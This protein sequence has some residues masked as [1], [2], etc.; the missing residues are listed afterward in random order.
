MDESRRLQRSWCS[1]GKSAFASDRWPHSDSV[2]RDALRIL[3][4]VRALHEAGY[5]RIRVHAGLSPSGTHWRCLITSADNV[6]KNGWTIKDVF[7]DVAHYSTG[8]GDA[9]FGWEDAGG[10]TEQELAHMFVDRFPDTA[11]CGAGPDRA[12]ADWF[13]GMMATAE[14]GR[15]PIFFADLAIDL[16]GVSTPPP[17]GDNRSTG[18][19]RASGVR[20]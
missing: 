11:E 18:D 10:R 13:A 16:S 2:L 17:P 4:L 14:T 6:E 9:A 20:D 7:S 15:L 12:Y 8:G 19:Q 3:S 5:Q 1:R